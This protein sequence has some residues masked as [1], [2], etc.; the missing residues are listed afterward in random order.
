MVETTK[1]QL[2]THSGIFG[3]VSREHTNTIQVGAAVD[4]VRFGISD[5]GVLPFQVMEVLRLN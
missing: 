4:S 5:P 3:L 1:G 2:P